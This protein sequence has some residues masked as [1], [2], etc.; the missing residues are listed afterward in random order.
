MKIFS[1]NLPEN[2][3]N[4]ILSPVKIRTSQKARSIEMPISDS[5]NLMLLY[6]FALFFSILIFFKKICF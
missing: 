1:A 5:V 2:R 6:F 4:I 3:A